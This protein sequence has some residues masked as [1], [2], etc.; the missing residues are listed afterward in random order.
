MKRLSILSL[1]AASLLLI[2]ACD[3]IDENEYVVFA[4]ASGTWYDSEATVPSVQRA[5]VE[6]YTGVRC[7]NCPNADIVLHDL[8]KKYGDQLI[9]SAIHVPNK[10][11]GEVARKRTCRRRLL[12]RGGYRAV[13]R[14][15][16]SA[17][18]GLAHDW[19]GV[20]WLNPPYSR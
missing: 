10:A 12:Q 8:G 7:V 1:L 3:K 18:C 14:C 13:E 6:K 4:G 20:V 11:P 17:V 19:H 9:I 16:V 5:F 15:V 2:T